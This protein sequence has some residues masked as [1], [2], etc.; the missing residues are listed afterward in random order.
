[1]RLLV[2]VG[3][4][5][6]AALALASPGP[7]PPWPVR[8]VDVAAKAGLTRPSVYG[9]L[10]KKRFIIE[11]N[12]AGAAFFD[13]DGDGWVGAMVLNGRRLEEGTRREGGWPG[14]AARV[15]PLLRR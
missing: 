5:L 15:G 6:L 2:F 1:M 7:T 3:P 12:G 14:G 9:G 8:L 13:A 11:T 4:A 10:E